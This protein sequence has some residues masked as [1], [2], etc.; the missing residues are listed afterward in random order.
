MDQALPFGLWST[1]K[2]FTAMADVVEWALVQAGVPLRIHY[3]D[4]FLFFIHPD[5]TQGQLVLPHILS[6]LDRLGIHP[7]CS[8]KDKGASNDSCLSSNYSGSASF[9]IQLPQ[10]KLDF[11]RG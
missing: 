11:I 3:E 1:P 6:I 8:S 9:E 10:Q 4:D 5:S 2:L 7:S